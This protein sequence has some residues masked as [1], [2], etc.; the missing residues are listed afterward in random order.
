MR[1]LKQ[2]VAGAPTSTRSAGL[3]ARSSPTSSTTGSKT[4]RLD[5][6]QRCAPSRLNGLSKPGAASSPTLAPAYQERLRTLNAV[7]FGDL[8]L[9]ST[10]FRTHEDVLAAT[11]LA[12]GSANKFLVDEYQDT[13]VAQYLWLRLPPAGGH[14][15]I[16]CVGTTINPKV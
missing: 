4:D 1:L 7:D 16:C 9:H 11:Y 2:L 6:R 3:R 12:A 13:N 15:N 5:T 14:G 10:I 8:L